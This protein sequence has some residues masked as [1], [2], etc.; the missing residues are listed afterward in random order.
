V[1]VDSGE[2]TREGGLTRTRAGECERR[3]GSN[4]TAATAGA[5]RPFYFIL[6]FHL[7]DNYNS[8]SAGMHDTAG[9][10][11]HRYSKLVIVIFIN[12]IPRV[13]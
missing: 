13:S 9:F 12:F 11:R 5:P 1:G 7:S 8:Y 6:F 2:R 3:Q 4:G 10:V